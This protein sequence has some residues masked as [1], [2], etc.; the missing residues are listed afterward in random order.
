MFVPDGKRF[1]AEHSL[2]DSNNGNRDKEETG[3]PDRVPCPLDPKHN[4]PVTKLEK[5]LKVCP[6]KNK[7][8]NDTYSSPSANLPTSSFSDR[9]QL[10][11]KL[12][13]TVGT[14]TDEELLA[15]IAKVD[16]FYQDNCLEDCL[17]ESILTHRVVEEAISSDQSLGASALK[18]LKQNSSLL[19]HLESTGAF[20]PPL[21]TKTFIEFGSGRGMLSYW[22]A[23]HL[24]DLSE[25]KEA[26]LMLIDKVSH[27]H[28]FDN[29]LK[30]ENPEVQTERVKADIVDVVLSKV[31]KDHATVKVTG[32]SKHLCGAATDFALQSMANYV[33]AGGTLDCVMIAL[34]C[35]H[36]CEWK[37]FVGQKYLVQCF[38]LET[39]NQFK[40]LCGLTS[41]A[42]CGTGRPRDKS[43]SD[44]PEDS[45][46]REREVSPGPYSEEQQEDRGPNAA[47]RYDHLHLDRKRRENIGK[48]VKRILDMARCTF[49]KEECGL[50]TQLLYYC[51]PDISLE[52]VVLLAKAK[53]CD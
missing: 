5:H 48:K 17:R 42:T 13:T 27:R 52:N 37:Y 36:R 11:P 2:N 20:E 39:V 51:D 7:K 46:S 16:T 50:D 40:I 38:G 23:K 44:L 35:H 19:G 29:R 22:M 3:Q 30:N 10:D 24:I 32:V 31:V 28:K 53:N 45:E 21:K 43:G 4:C 41:W 25:G 12:A 14:A 1:C 6:A 49:I 33:D 34:C 9:I 18:H 8:I 26:K 15:L 47:G